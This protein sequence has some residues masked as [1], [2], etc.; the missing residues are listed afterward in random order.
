MTRPLRIALPSA[1]SRLHAVV[2]QTLSGVL[3]MDGRA[4]EATRPTG[5]RALTRELASG[6]TVVHCRGTDVPMLVARGIVDVGFTGYDM[7][8][9][10]VLTT[11]RDLDVRSLSPARTSF[12]CFATVS[13]RSPIR[14]LYTEYP[15]TARRWAR[16]TSGLRSAE[17]IPLHGSLE[18]LVHAD[19][20][21]AAFVLVT[22]G[23]TIEANGLDLCTPIL[24]TD[25]CVV[26]RAADCVPLQGFPV[27]D[28][29]RLTMPRF[30]Q[31]TP[32]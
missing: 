7:S 14:R 1:T 3:D 5:R 18:G 10:A 13:G 32:G 19:P 6:D 9:E 26:R 12:V 24:A 27:D 8:V 22:S 28:L 21:S 15:A 16:A 17:V 4:G 20:E 2:A 11:G 29:P 25:M 23:E 30:C 31:S